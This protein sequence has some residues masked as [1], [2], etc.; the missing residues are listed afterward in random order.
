MQRDAKRSTEMQKRGK[1]DE[2]KKMLTRRCQKEVRMMHLRKGC[3][4]DLKKVS[5]RCKKDTSKKMMH[6]RSEKDVKKM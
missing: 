1:K 3:M 2:S 5:K 4:K 6:D